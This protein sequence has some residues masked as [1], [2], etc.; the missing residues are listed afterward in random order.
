M[1]VRRGRRPPRFQIADEEVYRLKPIPLDQ[2]QC[3]SRLAANGDRHR[4][5]PLEIR[6]ADNGRYCGAPQK[7]AASF[8]EPRPCA[9]AV[10][11]SPLS[12]RESRL[13]LAAYTSGFRVEPEGDKGSGAARVL[14]AVLL[15]WDVR[16]IPA[17]RERAAIAER[18][19]LPTGR[20]S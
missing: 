2:I 11:A 10:P 14:P 18:F 16:S 8:D 12:H 7:A 4:R 15:Q 3:R 17:P 1:D 6:R 9:R 13:V 19:G 20:L 5:A